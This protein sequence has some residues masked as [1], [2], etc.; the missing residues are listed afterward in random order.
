MTL[1]S[2]ERQ[3]YRIIDSHRDQRFVGIVRRDPAAYGWSW[4]AQIDFVDGENC[5]F[6]SQ[7]TFSTDIEA[8]DY[9][10]KFICDRIDSRLS[11]GPAAR[12]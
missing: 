4:K 1:V 8:K 10:R 6:V 7:R 3:R 5:S 9:M 11:L 2:Q 12:P